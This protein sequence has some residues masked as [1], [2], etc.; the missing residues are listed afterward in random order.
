MKHNIKLYLLFILFNTIQ[1]RNNKSTAVLALMADNNAN[2][3]GETT[4]SPSKKD[5][6]FTIFRPNTGLQV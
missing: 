6:M 4:K 1:I 3:K 5:I 2:K